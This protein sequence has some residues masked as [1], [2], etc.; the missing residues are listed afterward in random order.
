MAAP[1]TRAG[2]GFPFVRSGLRVAALTALLAAS[3]A[4]AA[5]FE[6]D[7]ARRAILDLRGRVEAQREAN[8]R[9]LNDMQRELQRVSGDETAA[10][11]ASLLQLQSQ[12]DAMKAEIATLRGQNEQLARDLS[13]VQRRQKDMAQ[14]VEERLKRFEP[15]KVQIDGREF[16]AD[17][18]EKAAYEQALA[19]FRQGDFERAQGGFNAFLA[20]YPKSGYG[21]SLLFWLGNAQYALKDYKSAMS[22]FR[23]LQ[24]VA[25]DHPRVPEGL[26]SLAN[27]QMEL[28][29]SRGAKKT[30]EDLVRL[31]PQ[32]E[33]AVVGR[34]RL[35]RI[36]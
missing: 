34:E 32:S 16:M 4:Q 25:P 8:E 33:A 19:Q 22:Q 10:L 36:K 18:A 23:L 3:S 35:Q 7:E 28:K 29:D 31:Y 15:V 26:L 11:R 27:S 2:A 5:L 9:R 17:P 6:D 30:L 1:Q 24:S 13:E 14:G 12:I 20:Q 21:P